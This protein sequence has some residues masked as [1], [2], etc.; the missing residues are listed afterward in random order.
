MTHGPVLLV[1]RGKNIWF[2][3]LSVDGLDRGRARLTDPSQL[4]G[5]RQ[6]TGS[7]P[8]AF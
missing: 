5:R 1:W 4:G 7:H 6:S 8:L 2:A 3:K